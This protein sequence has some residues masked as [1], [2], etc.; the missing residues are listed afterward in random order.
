VKITSANATAAPSIL[1]NYYQKQE[2]REAWRQCIRLTREIISQPAMDNYRGDEIQ[3]GIDI[4]SDAD[5]DKWVKENVESA[6][7]PAGTCK[8]GKQSDLMSV[9]DADCHVHGIENLRVIDASVFPTLPNGNIN[10]PVIMV[11]EK[12]AD[13]ILGNP[14]LPAA[15]IELEL[16]EQWE[17]KQRTGVPLRVS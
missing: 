4:T 5:I 2:D 17:T 12:V 14:A 8:M 13:V 9:V 1:F 6:Y 7:H 16:P 3:P 10:A 15:N 11:A